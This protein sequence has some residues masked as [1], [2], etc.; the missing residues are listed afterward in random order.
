MKH[1]L[2]L[3]LSLA[4]L[5]AAA[6]GQDKP[7]IRLGS[8]SFTES[9]VL[10]EL[11]A[12]LAEEAGHPV[13]HF[14]GLGGTR[15]V[16]ESLVSGQIDAYAEYSGTMIHEIL[17]GEGLENMAAVRLHIRKLGL[18]AT[19]PLGF[20]N[21]YAL[22]MK[23]SRAEELGITKISDLRDHP[24]LTLRFSNEFMQRGD[25]WPAL[26]QR[27]RL[28]HD[29]VRGLEHALAYE[30]IDKGVID[31]TDLYATDAKIEKLDLAILDDDLQ[32]FPEY[33]AVFV[34]RA[35]LED[36]APE[37]VQSMRDMAGRIDP[38]DMI[39]MNAAVELNGESDSQAAATFLN[40]ELR[41]D[42]TGTQ[43]SLTWKIAEYTLEHLQMV[44]LSLLAA[45]LVALPLGITAVRQESLAQPILGIVGI[46]QTIPAIALLVILI[47]PVSAFSE[48]LHL[49]LGLGF[50][51]AVVALFLYSLLPIVRNTY[52]GLLTIPRHIRESAEALGLTS[53]ARLW[54]V[55]LPIA[56]RTI[57]AGIKT[58][59]V[60]NV[61]FATLGG[62]IGAGGYGDPIFTGIRLNDYPTILQGAIPAALLALAVQGLFEIAERVLVPRGMRLKAVQ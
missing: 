54:L 35:A 19:A 38:A 30:S 12:H 57:L 7:E 58:A 36:T 41:L 1:L 47:R 20:N 13:E 59:A 24:E 42:V 28:P 55:E 8:K 53:W 11:L 26:A 56:S 22:G 51:Q 39:A 29:D 23:K 45:V 25:G 62:F 3:A 32:Y 17:A 31:V 15:L 5:T 40:E 10:G 18:R 44:G 9:V 48:M 37:F 49:D 50:P 52:T 6:G 61:G 2:C 46:I 33:N 21:T 14:A 16:W 34:Y 27:Y 4:A 60:I 43:Q